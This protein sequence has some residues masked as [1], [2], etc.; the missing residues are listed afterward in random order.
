MTFADT[1]FADLC[2]QLDERFDYH[3]AMPPPAD[4]NGTHTFDSK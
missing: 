1:P 4:W 2:R 3:R